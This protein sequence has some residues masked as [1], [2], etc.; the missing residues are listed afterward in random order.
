M[1]EVPEDLEFAIQVGVGISVP[2][3]SS[4]VESRW[5]NVNRTHELVQRTR[6]MGPTVISVDDPIVPG[7]K[8]QMP[9]RG[10]TC[11]HPEVSAPAA[12]VAWVA[13]D[14]LEWR[15][16]STLRRS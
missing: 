5:Y 10:T 6:G 15:R 12:G 8:I 3:I 1:V 9:V 16:F 7:Q 13:A 4:W 2:Y 14:D 11:N